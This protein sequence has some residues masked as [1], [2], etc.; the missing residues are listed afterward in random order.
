MDA[1]LATE[2]LFLAYGPRL[3]GLG[4]RLCGD[5]ADAED[6]VQETFLQVLRQWPA[7]R[8]ESDPGTWMFRIAAR[9]CGR[10][11]RARRRRREL[12]RACALKVGGKSRSADEGVDLP[13]VASAIEKGLC[14]MPFDMRACLVLKDVAGLS[15]A[16]IAESFGIPESTCKTRIHRA[17]LRLARGLFPMAPGRSLSPAERKRVAEGQAALDA[18]QAPGGAAA[19]VKRVAAILKALSSTQEGCRAFGMA[20]A[21][22]LPESLCDRVLLDAIGRASAGKVRAAGNPGN[23]PDPEVH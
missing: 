6:M 5:R 9:I 15:V 13:A 19:D 18:G 4:V 17:R 11:H 10:M 22:P 21:M 2:Q 7:F 20:A 8:G 23:F 14:T 1:A 12:D 16:A 3:Y